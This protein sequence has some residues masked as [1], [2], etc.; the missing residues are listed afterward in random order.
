MNEKRKVRA[1][2]TQRLAG[3]LMY[4]GFVLVDIKP[5]RSRPEM[6]DF[7]FN[8]SIELQKTINEYKARR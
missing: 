3:F 1:I 5:N 8:D 2:F 4:R 6:H 7:L